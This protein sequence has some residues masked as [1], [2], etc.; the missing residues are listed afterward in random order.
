MDKM[1]IKQYQQEEADQNI[2]LVLP[3]IYGFYGMLWSWWKG[4]VLTRHFNM[5][6]EK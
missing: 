4:K 5:K 2:S 6:C 3:H 1:K